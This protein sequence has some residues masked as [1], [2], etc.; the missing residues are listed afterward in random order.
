MDLNLQKGYCLA[1]RGE[2][3][4]SQGRKNVTAERDQNSLMFA[5]GLAVIQ[6]IISR[7]LGTLLDIFKKKR[8]NY[9]SEM[10]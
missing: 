10:T 2:G 5:S 6:P 3:D 9:L 1:K 4:F 8:G 7:G